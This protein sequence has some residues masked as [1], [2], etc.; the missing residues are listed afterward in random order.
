VFLLLLCLLPLRAD[1]QPPD[2]GLALAREEAIRLESLNEQGRY[3]EVVKLGEAFQDDLLE[4]AQVE[5]E[6]AFA[7]NALGEGDRA[8]RHFRRALELD[9]GDAAA[10]YDLGEVYLREGSLDEAGEAFARAAALRP[11]HWAGPFRLAEI[12]AR[13][14]EA[15]AFEAHLRTAL[16]NGFSFRVVVGDSNWLTYYRTPALRDVLKRLVTVY[17]DERLLEAFEQEEGTP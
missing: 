15:E 5:Y 8:R 14:G 4:S 16:R 12:A 17:S 7:W 11:E 3:P 13:R 9:P 6:I 2:Y 10:W 1:V